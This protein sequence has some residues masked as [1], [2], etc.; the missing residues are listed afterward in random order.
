MR[1]P[2]AIIDRLIEQRERARAAGAVDKKSFF[3]KIAD[4]FSSL[5]KN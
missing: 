2:K 5:F 4:F 3:A 1:V